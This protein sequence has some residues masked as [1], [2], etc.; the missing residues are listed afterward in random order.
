MNLDAALHAAVC[1][2][3]RRIARRGFPDLAAAVLR[4][5]ARTE[6]AE[7]VRWLE[8]QCRLCPTCGELTGDRF[9]DNGHLC[10][11]GRRAS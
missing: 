2:A 4:D 1:N 9:N 5:E 7:A 6:Q 3:A 8:A 10:S 11:R